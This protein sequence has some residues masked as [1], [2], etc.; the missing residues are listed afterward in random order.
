MVETNRT[1]YCIKFPDY[2]IKRGRL[3]T[4]VFYFLKLH[5]DVNKGIKRMKVH[6]DKRGEDSKKNISTNFG[7]MENKWKMGND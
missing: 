3:T 6:K 4:S 2:P 5:K 7:E 1:K